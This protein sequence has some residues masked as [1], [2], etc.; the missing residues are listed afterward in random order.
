MIQILLMNLYRGCSVPLKRSN[1]QK[2]HLNNQWKRAIE[3]NL[4]MCSVHTSVRANDPWRSVWDLSPNTI[5]AT[6][7][8]GFPLSSGWQ[9]LFRAGSQASPVWTSPY[10]E[11]YGWFGLTA[12]VKTLYASAKFDSFIRGLSVNRSIIIAF[13]SNV[14]TVTRVL[15]CNLMVIFFGLS[16]CV[17]NECSSNWINGFRLDSFD[18][19]TINQVMRCILP[20]VGICRQTLLD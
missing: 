17:L 1:H 10:F 9:Y 12:P 13:V 7:S 5:I 16:E 18:E 11:L 19:N 6:G 15:S 8:G 3:V 20:Q 14:G 2:N 4:N